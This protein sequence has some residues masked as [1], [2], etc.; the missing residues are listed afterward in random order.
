MAAQTPPPSNA[1]HSAPLASAAIPKLGE[2]LLARGLID[3]AILHI[4]LTQMGNFGEPLG[5]N[6]GLDHERRLGDWLVHENHVTR[7]EIDSALAEQARFEVAH[8]L[9]HH[10][11][12]HGPLIPAGERPAP[13][14]LLLILA[15]H[16]WKVILL[17][18]IA[19]LLTF[20]FLLLIP[21]QYSATTTVLPPYLFN[22]AVRP[23][24]EMNEGVGQKIAEQFSIKNQSDVFVGIL[25]SRP[26]LNALI[27]DFDLINRFSAAND[28]VARNQLT[29]RT[30]ISTTRDGMVAVVVTDTS[31]ELAANLA[32]AYVRE[33]ESSIQRYASEDIKKRRS[34]FEGQVKGLNDSLEKAELAFVSIQERTGLFKPE[35]QGQGYVNY[36]QSLRQN[37][38]FKQSQLSATSAYATAA[39]PAVLRLRAEISALQSELERA[40]RMLPG[41]QTS[42]DAKATGSSATNNIGGAYPATQ[43]P[44]LELEYNRKKR[45]V[46]NLETLLANLLKQTE[47]IGLDANTTLPVVKVLE[48]ASAPQ[49]ASSPRMVATPVLAFAFTLIAV[50]LAIVSYELARH[51]TA[52][53]HYVGRSRLLAALLGRKQTATRLQRR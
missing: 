5:S 21:K 42:A 28:E 10:T 44:Q 11:G 8:D 14:D 13:Y 47:S 50:L 3:A 48:P 27:R 18:G 17:P 51:L 49:R 2:I 43:P 6:S 39:H 36:V 30:Q 33:L 1:P 9:T 29:A 7:A 53:P 37:L 32:N 40:S 26:V 22:S 31:A 12:N 19:A 45:D 52:D 15:A 38:S 16:R 4:G 35:Q 34:F 20:L 41:G 25:K 46:Q 24:S 23:P